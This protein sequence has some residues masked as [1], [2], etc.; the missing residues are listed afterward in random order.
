MLSHAFSQAAT[1]KFSPS[2]FHPFFHASAFSSIS[3]WMFETVQCSTNL[4]LLDVSAHDGK[5]IFERF[6]FLSFFSRRL[7]PTKGDPILTPP[8]LVHL[9]ICFLVLPQ[10]ELQSWSL[11]GHTTTVFIWKPVSNG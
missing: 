11:I 3:T 8:F 7:L 4:N 5:L 10:N 6:C 9:Q 1:F 2:F